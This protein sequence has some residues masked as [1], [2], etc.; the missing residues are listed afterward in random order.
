MSN[1]ILFL[2]DMCIMRLGA[3]WLPSCCRWHC[4]CIDIFHR[5]D[6]SSSTLTL[7]Q[8]RIDADEALRLGLVSTVVEPDQLLGHA[9]TLAQ[10]IASYS[11]PVVAKAKECVNIAE[12]VGLSA[13]LSYER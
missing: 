13:G 11:H 6:T 2:P 1:L 8:C 9:V 10:K 7:T 12:E 4:R 5:A 3:L